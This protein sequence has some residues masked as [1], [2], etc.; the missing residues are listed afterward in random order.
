MNLVVDMNS[1]R[2]SFGFS[3]FVLPLV[4]IVEEIDE[5]AVKHYLE[6]SLKT[7]KRYERVILSGSALRNTVTIERRD[8]FEWIKDCN[9]PILGICAGMQT[10]GLVYGG[11][12]KRC[13]EIGM[14]EIITVKKNPLFS[15][16]FKAFSL[17]NLAIV[18]SA[19]F[20]VLAKSANCI[21]AVKHKRKE[22]YGVLFHPEVRNIEILQRFIHA[23][24]SDQII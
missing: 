17:H 11:Y 6:L 16:K 22:I 14:T 8:L 15:S 4:S 23:F 2:N 21:Q 18:P 3:E 9:I 10:A 19:E 12:L 13:C 1:A 5:C 24:S 7:L 20:E